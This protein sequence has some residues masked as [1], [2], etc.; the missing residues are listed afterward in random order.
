MFT[1]DMDN[2]KPI[3]DTYG[4]SAGDDALQ[5]VASVLRRLQWNGAVSARIGG[6]EFLLF[7]PECDDAGAE[8]ALAAIEADLELLN[9]ENGTKYEAAMSTGWYTTKLDSGVTLERCIR[10]SDERMYA[11]K[12]LKKLQRG[13]VE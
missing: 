13:S 2:L 3:N 7:L 6:D 9:R 8:K 12:R 10:E 11:V 5:T 1:F 4:H